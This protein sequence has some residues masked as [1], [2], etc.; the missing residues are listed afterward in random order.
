MQEIQSVAICIPT[1]NQAQYLSE[2][3]NSACNQTYSN[4]E[5]W[6]SDDASTDETPEVMAQLCQKFPQIH[7]YRQAHNL[8]MVANNSWIMRQPCTDYIVHLDSDDILEPN[9]VATLLALIEKYPEAGYAHSAV[10][11]I[12]EKGQVKGTRQL[13]RSQEFREAEQE[14]RAAVYG[15]RMA[16]NICLFRTEALQRVDFYEGR[17]DY[18]HDYD[19]IVR[20]A[21]T[22]Y[23]NVYTSKALAYYRVWTDERTVR[24]KRKSTELRGMIRVYEESLVPAFQRRGWDIKVIE[25]QRQRLALI[26]AAF[27]YRSLFT[28]AEQAEMVA[29]LKELGDSPALRF[30]FLALHWGLGPLFEWWY[31]TKMKSKG[32]LKVWLGQIRGITLTSVAK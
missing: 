7:Y 14:L 23:G 11:E 16:A 9:Y 8:G 3:I 10:R 29:L 20:M 15:Y 19:L 4:V 5:V 27:C 30:R 25:Q 24:P 31:T 22:G 13:A 32:V 1:F 2:A 21:D 6:V 28:E 18:T 17:P 26:H 12:D